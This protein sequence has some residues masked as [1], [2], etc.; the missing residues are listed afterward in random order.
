MYKCILRQVLV[1]KMNVQNFRFQIRTYTWVRVC[2]NKLCC[3]PWILLFHRLIWFCTL[4]TVGGSAR[5]SDLWGVWTMEDWQRPREPGHGPSGSPGHQWN[6]LVFLIW[7]KNNGI[8]KLI[9]HCV[10]MH[11]QGETYKSKIVDVDTLP[12]VY[13]LHHI[14]DLM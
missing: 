1:L 4:L 10:L 5:G 2:L 6:R 9:G 14:N 7:S 13:F 11:Y 12:L 8:L 3:K